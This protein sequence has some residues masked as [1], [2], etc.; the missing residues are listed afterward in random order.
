MNTLMLSGI[1]EPHISPEGELAAR[2]VLLAVTAV[3]LWLLSW[4]GRQMVKAVSILA[5]LCCLILATGLC[6]VA[7]VTITAQ[8]L[9]GSQ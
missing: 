8:A 9:M 1:L 5:R 3:C 7:L 4:A 2:G 6:L